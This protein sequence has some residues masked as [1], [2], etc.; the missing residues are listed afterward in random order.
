MVSPVTACVQA[1]VVMAAF[2]YNAAM[3]DTMLP[4]KPLPKDPPARATG[5]AAR[6]T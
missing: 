1:S 3:R 4:R 5:P 6:R 2:L